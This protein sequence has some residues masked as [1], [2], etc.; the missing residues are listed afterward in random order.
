[1]L[2]RKTI[3]NL[4]KDIL[5]TS[6]VTLILILGTFT[7]YYHQN[8]IIDLIKHYT[9]N[10]YSMLEFLQLVIIIITFS[11]FIV[12]GIIYQRFNIK[13]PRTLGFAALLPIFIIQITNESLFNH[14]I[15]LAEFGLKLILCLLI[16][17]IIAFLTRLRA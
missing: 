1:M 15:T 5:F 10:C 14:T 7:M 2:D 6:C 13:L 4:I 8:D 11:F 9:K 17:F 12:W 3:A 16:Y